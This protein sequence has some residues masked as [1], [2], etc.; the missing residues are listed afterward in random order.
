MRQRS[1]LALPPVDFSLMAQTRGP[2]AG[3]GAEQ[4]C[5]GTGPS[6]CGYCGFTGRV[7]GPVQASCPERNGWHGWLQLHADREAPRKSA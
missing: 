6:Y 3:P 4:M 7:M 2:I 1:R 5:V